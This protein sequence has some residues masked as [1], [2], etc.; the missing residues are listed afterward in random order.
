MVVKPKTLFDIINDITTTKA[1]WESYTESDQKQF[2]QYM[3][4]RFL[5]MN[6]SYL[7]FIA[8]VQPLTDQLTNV[9]YFKFY[10]DAIPKSAGRNFN[11]YIKAETSDKSTKLIKFISIHLSLSENEAEMMISTLDSEEIK[12]IIAQLKI[13]KKDISALLK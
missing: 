5:S 11:K 6:S 2:S 3:I 9:A 10:S 8:E 12:K 13:T 1:K 7:P 4:N